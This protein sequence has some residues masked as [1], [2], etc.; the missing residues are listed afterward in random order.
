M[1]RSTI[2]YHVPLDQDSM[3][4]SADV[5]RPAK[6]QR[7]D[8]V[9]NSRETVSTTEKTTTQERSTS[10]AAVLLATGTKHYKLFEATGSLD[11][12]HEAFDAVGEACHA[13]SKGIPDQTFSLFHNQDGNSDIL[14]VLR[15]DVETFVNMVTSPSS[16]LQT[17]Q[18]APQGETIYANTPQHHGTVQLLQ[19]D[20]TPSISKESSDATMHEQTAL[21]G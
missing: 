17:V 4:R 15:R 11:D 6:R 13:T 5:P 2:Y 9:G 18:S 1:S 12:L 19:M 7:R 3:F 21:M 8:S 20:E 10:E 16:G 14:N